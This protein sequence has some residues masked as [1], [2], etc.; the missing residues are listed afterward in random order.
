MKITTFFHMAPMCDEIPTF[1]GD[2]DP[3]LHVLID[4]DFART[5]G[6]DGTIADLRTASGDRLTCS[7]QDL[8]GLSG[9]S[10]W[11]NINSLHGVPQDSSSARLVAVI[12]DVYSS[13]DCVRA[14]WWKAV[15]DLIY[16][17]F[18][19]L[20]PAIEMWRGSHPPVK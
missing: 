8:G 13:C 14:T 7:K 11:R 15:I 2:Y 3:R 16:K 17:N 19:D 5:R 18:H 6:T 4:M 20:H 1:L 10:V 9:G 12:T